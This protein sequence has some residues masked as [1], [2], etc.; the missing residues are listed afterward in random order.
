M[1]INPN[2]EKIINA[3]IKSNLHLIVSKLKKYFQDNELIFIDIYDSFVD[4][5]ISLSEDN[6]QDVFIVTCTNYDITNS[7]INYIIFDY[8]LKNHFPICFEINITQSNVSIKTK[9]PNTQIQFDN[10]FSDATS[11]EKTIFYSYVLNNNA[12][13]Y[14]I[15]NPNFYNLCKNTFSNSLYYQFLMYIKYSSEKKI[16][17]AQIQLPTINLK[18]KKHILVLGN[19]Y[20][21]LLSSQKSLKKIHEYYDSKDYEKALNEI[22]CIGTDI[23]LSRGDYFL[24][25]FSDYKQY[26]FKFNEYYWDLFDNI[27][28]LKLK[29]C[30]MQNNFDS[31]EEEKLCLISLI[32]QFIET[33]KLLNNLVFYSSLLL[34]YSSSF[35]KTRWRFYSIVL[36]NKLSYI[37]ENCSIQ[38]IMAQSKPLSEI[39]AEQ[40]KSE[41]STTRLQFFFRLEG[42]YDVYMLRIDLQHEGIPYIHINLEETLGD[43][44]ISSGYPIELK[45]NDLLSEEC[46]KHFLYKCTNKYWFKSNFEKNFVEYTGPEK[47]LIRK[48]FEKQCHY[49]LYIHN[50]N[51]FN[52]FITEVINILR[53]YCSNNFFELTFNNNKIENSKYL[54]TTRRK[55]SFIIN[56]N[57]IF[58]N[59]DSFDEVLVEEQVCDDILELLSN[60][61]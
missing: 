29:T 14:E 3:F 36:F 9:T 23:I 41:D 54:S 37:F 6:Y 10:I 60:F 38:K 34:I 2:D 44:M 5:L 7:K 51:D 49:K 56:I 27:K 57:S 42:N 13:Y 32:D 12:G 18:S 22:D 40:R 59:V 30:I 39:T 21:N 8:L 46:I 25:Q 24:H 50:E 20:F 28:Q 17:G 16:K 26:Y 1:L 15:N 61:Y 43:S 11:F 53:F 45:I 33:D 52:Y 55:D 48:V 31:I 47:E 35:F 4:V 19:L 58:K